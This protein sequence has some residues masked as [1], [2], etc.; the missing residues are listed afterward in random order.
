VLFKIFW[1]SEFFIRVT[2][3][4]L[5]II[6]SHSAESII[7]FSHFLSLGLI[8]HNADVIYSLFCGITANYTTFW[9]KKKI[10]A[11]NQSMKLT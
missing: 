3:L 9:A 6:C 10:F 2:T 7:I 5:L 8:S 11:Q 1:L 4:I